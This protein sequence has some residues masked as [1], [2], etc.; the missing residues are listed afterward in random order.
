MK[1]AA[2]IGIW[3][4]QQA[5]VRWDWAESSGDPTPLGG[6]TMAARSSVMEQPF[7]F[8]KIT[9]VEAEQIL[10]WVVPSWVALRRTS[11]GVLPQHQPHYTTL[12]D[13]HAFLCVQRPCCCLGPV[14]MGDGDVT[15]SSLVYHFVAHTCI[16][17]P[18]CYMPRSEL[19]CLHHT[20]FKSTG[21]QGGI[22]FSLGPAA[23]TPISAFVCLYPH[24]AMYCWCVRIGWQV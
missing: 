16:P 24:F 2:T 6:P 17:R 3:K 23:D 20:A 13:L 9:R 22:Y 12:Y 18:R 8:G 15:L 11:S 14:T 1:G 21:R 19:V 5:G 4:C 7:F 10:R